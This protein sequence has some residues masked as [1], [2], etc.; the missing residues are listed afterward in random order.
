[1][2]KV[3]NSP[4]REKAQG[5][6][7]LRD[8]VT[9]A[10]TSG[11]VAKPEAAGEPNIREIREAVPPAPTFRARRYGSRAHCRGRRSRPYVGAR[12]QAAAASTTAAA[13]KKVSDDTARGLGGVCAARAHAPSAPRNAR[14]HRHEPSAHS[15]TARITLLYVR[16][17]RRCVLRHP[18]IRRIR[19]H[20]ARLDAATWGQ[21]TQRSANARNPNG[22]HLGHRVEQ[23]CAP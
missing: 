19:R 15:G 11:A 22:L 14:T 13:E 17:Q 10:P 8:G 9:P 6:V 1:M 2:V 16:P 18:A 21:A 5:N 23:H 3:P 7:M 20:A 4:P 12:R